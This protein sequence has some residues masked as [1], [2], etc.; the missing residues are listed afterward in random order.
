MAF[1]YFTSDYSDQVGRMMFLFL[2]FASASA[3]VNLT[4][5]WKAES[6]K[7]PFEYLLRKALCKT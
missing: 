5:I 3:S 7:N 2:F 6:V 1:S 4:E